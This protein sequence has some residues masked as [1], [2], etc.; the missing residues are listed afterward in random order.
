[1]DPSQA[2]TASFGGA[3]S[4]GRVGAGMPAAGAQS[5]SAGI[6][7]DGGGTTLREMPALS[8][9]RVLFCAGAA[10]SLGAVLSCSAVSQ[11]PQSSCTEDQACRDGFGLAWACNQDSGLCEE[12][13]E[14]ELCSGVY[15]ADLLTD[16]DKYPGDTILFATLLDGKGDIQMIRSANL[17]IEQVRNNDLEGRAFGMINCSYGD[18]MDGMRQLEDAVE[19][20]RFAV[21]NYGVK[22][23]IGPGTSSLAEAVYNEVGDEV[24]LV[25]PSATSDSLTAI[26]GTNK[27]PQNPGTFWRTAPPDSGIA[28]K[29]AEILVADNRQRV[30]LIFK[31]VTYGENLANLLN[32]SLLELNLPNPLIKVSYSN[33]SVDLGQAMTEVSALDVDE[34]VFIADS[35]DDVVSFLNSAAS[36]GADPE[37]SFGKATLMLGDAGFSE[38]NVLNMLSPTMLSEVFDVDMDGLLNIRLVIPVAPSGNV[39]DAFSIA[40]EATFDESPANNGYTAESY[41][42]AWLAIY[43][44]A[45]SLFNEGGLT[46]KG[47]GAGLHM[48]SSGAEVEING[49]SWTSIRASFEAEQTVNVIGA[50]GLLDYDS[51]TEET[52]G[53][54]ELRQFIVEGGVLKYSEAGS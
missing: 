1:M 17:A 45:W 19:A 12:V 8:L 30:A 50:S 32:K 36:L 51:A 20:A 43:G 22:A 14:S 21:D 54:G 18:D 29:M 33:A 47:M 4:R 5:L 48:L 7:V 24:L 31:E 42:A 27:S 11:I 25:S 38:A 13:A 28:R 15:P 44:A 2:P 26:D 49:T 9:A 39:F 35:N 23:I 37:S 41:D 40:Y 10:L 6:Q 46:A 16:P 3:S 52:T 53:E 34:I